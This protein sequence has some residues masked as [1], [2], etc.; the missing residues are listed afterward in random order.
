MIA[1]INP[2]P[3]LLVTIALNDFH[4]LIVPLHVCA[5]AAISRRARQ[6]AFSGLGTRLCRRTQ[7]HG[8]A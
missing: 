6:V 8:P 4:I 5:M 1:K 7:R 2:G 3:D